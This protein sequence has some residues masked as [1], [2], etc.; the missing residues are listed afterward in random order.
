MLNGIVWEDVGGSS[1]PED[2]PEPNVPC[3]IPNITVRVCLESPCQA[4]D[5]S[6]ATI[7]FGTAEPD[8]PDDTPVPFPVTF[9]YGAQGYT[10]NNPGTDGCLDFM[11]CP[12]VTYYLVIYPPQVCGNDPVSFSFRVDNAGNVR[13][14]NKENGIPT[15][16]AHITTTVQ[17]GVILFEIPIECDCSLGGGYPCYDCWE[18]CNPKCPPVSR[19]SPP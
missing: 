2:P 5:F 6:T 11:I 1:E 9:D 8:M 15:I 17:G 18:G 7:G 12:N 13:I 14:I 3:S 4:V 10:Q 19:I 16:G